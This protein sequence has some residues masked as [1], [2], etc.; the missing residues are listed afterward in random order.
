MAC[1]RQQK[2]SVLALACVAGLPLPFFFSGP[3]S[4]AM[5]LPFL[6]QSKQ[7]NE[8]R[9]NE[10]IRACQKVLSIFGAVARGY[11]VGRD[12]Q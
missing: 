11:V 12:F 7:S 10:K 1:L 6:S 9:E 2:A 5:R 3:L 4:T 8:I